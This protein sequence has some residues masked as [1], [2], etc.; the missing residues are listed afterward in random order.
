MLR[1]AR[2]AAKLGFT[3]HP[4]T[5]APLEELSSLLAGVPPARLFDEA[6]KLFL[7]GHA[8]AS[9]ERL[10]EFHLLP[11]LFPAVAEE[12]ARFPEGPS[13]K[14]LRLGLA[15]TDA[16][17]AA[18]LSVTPTF[19][20]AVLLY[21]PIQR[22]AEEKIEAGMPAP[23]AF[24]EAAD[25]VIYEQIRRVAVPKRFTLPM[26]ELLALQP[27]FEHRDGRRTLALLN[28][29]RFRAA[30]DFMVLR[31]EAG[32][33]PMEIATWWTEIQE[34]TS[35]ERLQRV[36]ALAPSGTDIEGGAVRRRRRRRG[37]R[38]RGGGSGPDVPAP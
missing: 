19:L 29:P 34:V 3:L 10:Q 35:E 2:F 14:L 21:G 13:A 12:L 27:R 5:R 8:V 33:I 31:A 4:A 23:H 18:D 11:H 24:V 9:L 37:R 16:R 26:R 28:H 30:Y 22:L 32:L 1:A 38:G 7:S 15:N 36:Q 17:V 20:F 6:M 25:A